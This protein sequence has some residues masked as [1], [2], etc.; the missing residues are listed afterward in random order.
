MAK[1]RPHFDPL[2]ARLCMAAPSFQTSF[3]LPQQGSWTPTVYRASPLMVDIFGTG[4]DDIIAVAPGARLIAYKANPDGSAVPQVTY[5]VPGG[6]ADIKSTPIVVTDPRTGQKELFAAMGRDEIHPGA[7]EDG[8]VFGWDLRTG[9]L[10]PG[11]T[12]GRSTGFNVT[13]YSGVYGSLASGNLEDNGLPDIVVTSF[14]HN[15]TAFRLDGSTLW[16]WT[17]DDTILSGAV[18]GD[19][20]RD[21]EPEVI[22]GGDSSSSSFYQAGGWVNVLSNKGI[23]LWR[24][25]IPGEVTWSSPVLAD[26]NNNGLLDIVIGTGLNYQIQGVPGAQVAGDQIFAFDP[27][28]NLLPGWPNRT[29]APTN[30]APHEVLAAPAVADLMGNGQLDII[31]IDRAGYLHVVQPNGQ[32]LNGF[33]GGRPIAPDLPA[34]VIPDDYASPIVVDVD[35]DG[36]PEIVAAAG[37]FLRA[38]DRFGNQLFSA[39]TSIPPGGTPE[40]IDTAAAVGHFNGPS[41][42]PALAFV[43]YNAQAQNRPDVVQVFRLPPS[44]LAPPWPMLRQTASA[45]AIGHSK[46]FDR[47]F[48]TFSYYA[49]LGYYPNSDI[50]QPFINQLDAGTNDLITTALRITS[51]TFARQSEVQRLYKTILGRDA[52]P[53][54]LAAYTNYL[55]GNTYQSLVIQFAQSGEFARRAGNDLGR[56]VVLLYQALVFRTPSQAEVNAQIATG[57]PIGGIARS[58]LNSDEYLSDQL[59][60][61]YHYAFG[62]G[63]ENTVPPDAKAAF[64]YDIHHGAREEDVYARVFT[65]GYEYASTSFQAGYVRDLYRDI[66]HRNDDPSEVALY[67]RMLDNG[68]LALTQIP[69]LLLNS[70]EARDNY[71]QQEFQAL[72]GHPADPGTVASLH[73]YANRESVVITLVGSAEYYSRNGGTASN[74][75]QA[76]FRDLAGIAIDQANLDAFVNKLNSGALQRFQVA[77]Q[78]IYGGPLY[79]NKT[80]VDYIFTYLPDE[81]LGVLRSANLPPNAQGQPVNPSPALINYLMGLVGQGVNDEGII[82]TLLTSPGYFGRVAYY[83]GIYRS[84]GIRN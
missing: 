51:S 22:V 56:E 33:V 69:G 84:P 44:G 2:E 27:N 20:N 68:S 42:P 53:G 71:I 31:A 49:L 10:L 59:G 12:Q 1:R 50:T 28:G 75:V 76:A 35:G 54:G 60:I 73:N 81:S 52:D 15:V 38:F 6:V 16:Q 39:T 34:S 79:F 48:V 62:P 8:R 67:L 41:A 77:Q 55:A 24:R 14:S 25:L 82:A 11:W 7:L 47:N 61:L 58:M 26:L 65:T 19:I 29:T 43:S 63:A 64:M 57:Q 36:A 78:I 9:Q 23:L 32:D 66:L 80:I 70:Y 37:P 83:K 21:G 45:D 74:F 3:E 46:T 13:G 40:G 18:V 4:Q 5:Q 30:P 72:V 17:N